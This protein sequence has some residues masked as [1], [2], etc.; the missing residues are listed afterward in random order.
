[1]GSVDGRGVEGIH[2]ANRR[3]QLIGWMN[4]LLPEFSLPPD[5]SSEELRE[6]LSDGVVLCRL[7]NTLIPGGSWEGYAPSDQRLG[8]VKK[9]LSV[10]SDMGLP[11]FSLKDLDEVRVPLSVVT[12]TKVV[13]CLLVLRGSVDPRLGDDIPP[14]VTR[15][16]LR[17]QWGVQEMDK[18]Q[19]PAAA[20]GKRSPAED[21][22]NGVADSKTHQKTSVFSGQKVRE[23]FQLKRGSYSDLTAAKI[24]E[25]MHSN[26]LDNAPT[27]SLISVV[28]GILDESIERKK[29]EIPHRVVYLLRKVV[30]EIEH[31]LCIQAEHIRSQNV[32]IK[33]REQKYCSKIKALEMLVNG[34]NEENQMA[35]NRLQIVKNEKSQIEEKKELCEKDVQRLMKEKEYSKSIIMNLTKDMEA[36]NRLHEQQLEQIG[37]KAKEMEEQLTTRVKEVEYLLL[38]S[39]KKVEE[40]EI[41]SRLKSQ[42]WDQKENIF[43][44]YMDNQQLVIKDIRILSQS[45]END[46]YALQM[47]W[48][49]EISNLGSGLKCLVDAA[50]NYHKVLTENQKLFNE[51]QE[52]KGNIRVYCRVRPFLSGQDKK[53]TTIDYMGENGE[54]LISNPFK[55]G[56]DG[57][58]MFKFNKVFTPFASQAEVFSDIQPLIRSVLD[59]FN[60][61]IF[62]Y[63]QTGSG[64]TYTMSGPTTSKQDWGVNYRALNDLFDIS[65]NASLHSVKSTSDVLDL[66]EIGQANR[67]VG[68]TALNERSSRSHSILTVHVRGM[69][70]K[71]GSTSRGCLHLIDL[72][73]SERVEK[74]EVTG[75]RLKEAQ[76]INKSLSALGDVIFALSQKS[77]HVPYRNSKLTQVLQSSLGG[78][79]KTLMFVQINPD[80]ESY[81]ETISTLKFAERVS[82][83]ELGAARSNKEGKD[84][85]ELLEQVASLKDTILR[86][87][88]EIEQIQVIKDKSYGEV[89]VDPNHHVMDTAPVSIDEAGYENNASDDGLSGET[90]NDNSAAEMTA[91][92]LHRFPSRISRFTLTKNGQPSMSRSNPKDAKTPS[93]T[94]AP[95]SRLTGGSSARSKR[96]Q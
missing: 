1:M 29:G 54:L 26:S 30:Q 52:L 79:A 41:A 64:K 65:L 68:S 10:V 90:E 67:A 92:R 66:M 4:A 27:Q 57:H 76:Y 94:K 33:T 58:R 78:Q 61:C 31:R 48:R 11:G 6:L 53:S 43:Q 96:R 50:E 28:N 22:R 34:T 49:N 40:L 32:T 37:R 15:T 39:N 20:L 59:G 88:M 24:S 35:I 17:K 16:P 73:G 77:A 47:Q 56:K 9:F 55:Q 21:M 25:M 60:V 72:A 83:V 62:A 63:G 74:S 46:M 44:S 87:D 45:Y 7:V 95:S 84:I 8:N 36:M 38:Q 81:S 89:N 51:V 93:N 18:P 86:K 19:V 2:E 70:L 85:K 42:L 80:V 5:S 12:H 14:D 23:V 91:E 69:D 71:N 82:G 75:D 3:A 13:E